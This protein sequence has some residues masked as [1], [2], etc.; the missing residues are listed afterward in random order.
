[1]ARV[2][3][4]RDSDSR[5][6]RAISTAVSAGGTLAVGI[7]DLA[8][9]T[10]VQ[11]FRV[12][13]DVGSEIGGTLVDAARGSVRAA[14]DIGNDLAQLSR[15]VAHGVAPAS[16]TRRPL[17]KVAAARTPPAKAAAP[18]RRGPKRAASR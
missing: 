13:E 17:A 4:Q 9:R 6:S 1:M 10:L 12:A 14:R 2:N 5:A 8:G 11:A 3:R 18:R 16:P 7:V 15:N